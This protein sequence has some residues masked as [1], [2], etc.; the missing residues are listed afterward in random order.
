MNWDTKVLLYSHN[1]EAKLS[2][3]AGV[4][5]F[6]KLHKPMEKT[7]PLE[8]QGLPVFSSSTMAAVIQYLVLQ[9]SSNH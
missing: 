2:V 4:R 1:H 9:S 8:K 7:F 6:L 3:R 5:T